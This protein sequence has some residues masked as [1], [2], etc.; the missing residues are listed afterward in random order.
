VAAFQW[1]VALLN[2]H[3]KTPHNSTE[4]HARRGN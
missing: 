4:F 3:V 2:I 1:I